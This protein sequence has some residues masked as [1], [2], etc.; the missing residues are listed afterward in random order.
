MM[1]PYLYVSTLVVRTG[2]LITVEAFQINVTDSHFCVPIKI[3]NGNIKRFIQM[4]D[5]I[6]RGMLVTNILKTNNALIFTF[7]TIRFVPQQTALLNLVANAVGGGGSGV[8]PGSGAGAAAR[9]F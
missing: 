4:H 7:I 1:I 3:N 6:K 5:A 8:P 2:F 9:A